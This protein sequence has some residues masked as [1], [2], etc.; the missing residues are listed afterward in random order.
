MTITPKHL[1]DEEL[2]QALA[3]A[4]VPTLL[5]LLVQLTGEERWIEEPYL[6]RRNKGLDDNNDGGLPEELQAEIRAAGLEAIRAWRDG[7]PVALPDPGPELMVRMLSVAMGE[8][9]GEEYGPMLAAELAA[10]DA[11]ATTAPVAGVPEGFHALIVGAGVSGIAA[12]IRLRDAGI[13]FTI[14]EQHEAVG[15]TW[16]ENRYP[17]CGVDTPSA[18]YSFSFAPHDWSKYFALRDELYAYLEQIVADT[19]LDEEIRFQTEVTGARYDEDAQRWDVE[20]RGPGG[21]AETLT[22]DLVISAVGAFRRPKMPTIPGLEDFAGELVHT[23][24]WPDDLDLTG[25]RVAVIGNGASAMQLVPAIAGVAAAV[26]IFQRSPQ[27]AAPFELFHAEVPEP[28]RELSQSVPLYRAWY[29]LRAG[30]TFND[31]IHQTLQKDPDWPHPERSVNEIND[32]HRRFFTRY[33]ESKLAG[34]PDLVEKVTP[35]YP[36]YGKRILLDNGWYDSLLRDDVELVT[37]PIASVATDR[38]ITATGAEHEV[39]VIV[40]ATGFDVVRFLAPMDIRG[41]GGVS[42]REVWDDDDARAYLGSFVPGFPNF[43]MIYGPNIAG[44]HGGSL[45]GSAEHQLDYLIDL[46]GRLFAQGQ[47]VAEVRPEPYERHNRRVDEA[48]ERMVWTHPGMDTYYRNG[49][50]RV[51]VTTPFRVIDFWGMTRS[52]DLDDF[53]TEPPREGATA[54]AGRRAA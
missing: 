4:N 40:A 52:A 9:V 8:E 22:A 6:P 15:G 19:G 48:H 14:V 12:A 23:A 49:H 7:A 43:Y 10:V 51:V 38:V 44:G 1:S 16:L 50:G 30:W 3:I 20:L 34:R 29:R 35:T 25:R 28:L 46:L 24:R 45:I 53:V 18:L 42:L 37:D 47:V 17:G 41:R 5:P 2:A 33:I 27:W 21:T 31:R 11:P 13:P 26:T 54:G 32:G 36:P 39:D